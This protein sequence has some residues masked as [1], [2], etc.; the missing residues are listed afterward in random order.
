MLSNDYTLGTNKISTTISG[1]RVHFG[2]RQPIKAVD[3]YK[4]IVDIGEN[5]H[6]LAMVIFGS[7][8]DWWALQDINPPLDAF[9]NIVDGTTLLLPD[10]IVKNVGDRQKFFG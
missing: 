2:Y 10:S 5:F 6:T 3:T 8:T 7:D 4:Y 9:D 1:G